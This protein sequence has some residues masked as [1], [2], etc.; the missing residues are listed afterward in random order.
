MFDFV[1]FDLD[2][3]LTDPKEGITNCVKYALES[4]GITEEDEAVLLR[5]IGPPLIDSFTGI[6]GM[7]KTDAEKAVEKYRE[8]F[9]KT[10]L[11]ENALLGGAEEILCNL[12]KKGIKTALA[13]SKP[14]VYAKRIIENYGIDKYFDCAVGSELDGTRNY[15]DEV[16]AEVLKR[17]KPANLSKVVMIGDRK[18]DIIGS[19]K[20]GIASIGLRC[21]YAEPGELEA[22]GADYIFNNIFELQN[23]L[24]HGKI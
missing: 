19:K 15:K 10:G 7:S 22:A 4:F 8:R 20:C 14:Y 12:K 1:L 6:Y 18:H 23:F 17:I 9:S 11:F 21:G 2:G 3:T 16:I 13:T 24:L 5:F